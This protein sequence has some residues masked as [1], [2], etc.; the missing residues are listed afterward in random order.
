MNRT[1]K[2]VSIKEFREKGYLQE[3]NRRFFH[4]L[5][6]ALQV[7]DNEDGDEI[8]AGIQDSTH[9]MEGIIFGFKPNDDVARAKADLVYE[10]EQQRR[11]Q[12][13]RAIGS[14]IEPIPRNATGSECDL[15]CTCEKCMYSRRALH[16]ED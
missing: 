2:Q 8:L 6:M 3:V 4:P 16:Q 9:D 15:G 11:P 12:R 13:A 1:N 10:D 14:W 7:K 5:G